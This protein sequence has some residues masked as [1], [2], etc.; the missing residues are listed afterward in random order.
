MFE[1]NDIC[2]E[3]LK[4]LF[5]EASG[6]QIVASYSFFDELKTADELNDAKLFLLSYSLPFEVL[7][8]V[9]ELLKKRYAD[10]PAI[11]INVRKADN[12]V[13]Q[14]IMNG[15]KSI[16]W[17]SDSTGELLFVCHKLLNGERYL[18]IN[19]SELYAGNFKNES[20][21]L[22][23]ISARELTVLKLFAL[24]HSYK[25][26]GEKLNISPRTVESHKNNIQAKPEL[27]S[28]KELIGYVIKNNIVELPVFSPPYYKKLLGNLKSITRLSIQ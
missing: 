12:V 15:I 22:D 24:G 7:I 20:E 19:E 1:D 25:L 14:C 5:N 8:S 4:L 3:A 9:A 13:L 17:K 23:K 18:R 21:Y 11:L 26:I 27:S 2:R 6:F 16:I 10:I 28:L